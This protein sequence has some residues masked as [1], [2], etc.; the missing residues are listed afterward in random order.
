MTKPRTGTNTWEDA[1]FLAVLKEIEEMREDSAEI[2]ATARGKVMNNKKREK[3]KIKMAKQE[4]GIDSSIL[5]TVL[6]QR[7][8]ERRLQKLA[9]NVS[10]DMIDLYED[11]AGQFSLF[12]PDEGQPAVPAAQAAAA[13]RAAQ[14]QKITDEEQAAG[15]EALDELAGSEVV[16]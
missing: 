15:A 2:M 1:D 7:E 11:C 13:E 4:L 3:N 9:E 12:A 6:K 10:D 5:T 16:H 8:I 14:V